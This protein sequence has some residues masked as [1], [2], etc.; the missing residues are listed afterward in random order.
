MLS[1]LPV[2]ALVQQALAVLVPSAFIVVLASRCLRLEFWTHDERQ[3]TAA[4]SRG[5]TV[6]GT[7]AESDR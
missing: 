3:A 4:L 7:D 5:L 6:R 2:R 1:G